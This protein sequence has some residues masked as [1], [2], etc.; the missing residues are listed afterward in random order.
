MVNYG[1]SAIGSD[2]D[3]PEMYVECMYVPVSPIWNSVGCISLIGAEMHGC[4]M[5]DNVMTTSRIGYPRPS[6]TARTR[7]KHRFVPLPFL[8]SW[9]IPRVSVTPEGYPGRLAPRNLELVET[10]RAVAGRVPV[11]WTKELIKKPTLELH[12]SNGTNSL[13]ISGSIPNEL[14]SFMSSSFILQPLSAFIME[15]CRR[16]GLPHDKHLGCE[17]VQ[18]L[19]T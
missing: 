14:S 3:D 6:G 8:H 1:S 18:T 9:C 13:V 16:P 10:P 4:C 5:H 12:E 7:V 11:R 17:R 15:K 19:G 2:H